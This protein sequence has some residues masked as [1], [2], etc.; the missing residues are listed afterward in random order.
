MAGAP[1]K[2][3]QEIY[4]EIAEIRLTETPFIEA[5]KN[6]QNE[7]SGQESGV[8]V[9]QDKS[10]VDSSPITVDVSE[11]I[12]VSNPSFQNAMPSSHNGLIIWF[13]SLSRV[14]KILY[15]LGAFIVSFVFLCR[16]CLW[17][18]F[19]FIGLYD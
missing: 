10:V 5:W 9:I 8:S 17:T 18:F 6:Q 15:V 11:S 7:G 16:I 19:L 1:Q 3:I 12:F 14:G 2:K 4:A 13:Y